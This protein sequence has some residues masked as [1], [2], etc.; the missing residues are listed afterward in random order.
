MLDAKEA[1]AQGPREG[2]CEARETRKGL[3][4]MPSP[5]GCQRWKDRKASYRKIGEGFDPKG[6]RVR[7]VSEREAKAFVLA[8]HYAGTMPAARR[9]VGLFRAFGPLE[10]LCGAAVFSVPAQGRAITAHLGVEPSR[11][12]ELGRFVLAPEVEG[13][14]E[15]FFGA[16]ALRLLGDTLPDVEGVL[17]YSD[18]LERA[19]AAGVVVK[20]GHIGTIYQALGANYLGTSAARWLLLAR[21]GSVL[22]ERTVSKVRGE[23]RGDGGAY[24]MMCRA[25]LGE[26]VAMES[27]AAY[28]ERAIR[29]A[30][31]AGVLRRIKHTGNHIYTFSL[32]GPNIEGARPVYPKRGGGDGV[33][34][35]RE[36]VLR[37]WLDE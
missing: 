37:G 16:R 23:E 7:L 6:Y 13:N 8:H 15:S 20:P 34:A 32:R 24:K 25:G 28:V 12:V 29:E 9:C 10:T 17:S 35:E 11:G 14:A 1:D 19:D 22:S 4:C 31:S 18:P 26:R 30:L 27:G 3:A 5:Q 2:S 33:C 21:D 36:A